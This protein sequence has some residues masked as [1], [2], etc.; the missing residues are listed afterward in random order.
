MNPSLPGPWIQPREEDGRRDRSLHGDIPAACLGFGEADG[1]DFGIG[2][3][4]TRQRPVAGRLVCLAEDVA[5]CYA[6]LIHRDVRERPRASDVAGRPHAGSGTQV[7]VRDNERLGAVDACGGHAQSL[8][9]SAP[10]GGN[11]AGPGRERAP[12]RQGP[13]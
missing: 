2:E 7:I 9:V 8:Q 10:P 11:P 3:G 13:P 6:R 1:S 4:H 12:R 5:G